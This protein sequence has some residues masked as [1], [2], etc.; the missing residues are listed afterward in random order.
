M[1]VFIGLLGGA[2]FGYIMMKR[3][4]DKRLYLILTKCGLPEQELGVIMSY[5]RNYNR[6]CKE[7]AREQRNQA[8]K[9]EA[10]YQLQ[11]LSNQDVNLETGEVKK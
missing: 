2:V 8:T 3:N 1:Q 5:Y 10:N 9:L 6:I 11:R 7:V 4:M